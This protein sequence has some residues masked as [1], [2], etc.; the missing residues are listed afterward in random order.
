[1]RKPVV[2]IPSVIEMLQLL[3]PAAR[4]KILFNIAQQDPGLAKKIEADLFSFEDLSCLTP[5]MTQA[6]LREVA[7]PT[8]LLALRKASQSLKEHFF[9]NMSQRAAALLRDDLAA[10]TPKRLA[11]VTAAQDEIM[12]IA[13]KLEGEG[14]LLLKKS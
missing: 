14:K 7:Q 4:K 3:D 9:A 2:G 12:S 11:D 5:M 13:K 10:Q 8:L 6:L 1:M